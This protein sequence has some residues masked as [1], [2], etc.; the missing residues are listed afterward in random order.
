MAGAAAGAALEFFGKASSLFCIPVANVKMY[1]KAFI[2]FLFF[3]SNF[4]LFFSFLFYFIV[5]YIS[6]FFFYQSLPCGQRV[7]G[8]FTN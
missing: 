6:F 1:K 3:S 4:F 2:F 8:I 5:S 7:M